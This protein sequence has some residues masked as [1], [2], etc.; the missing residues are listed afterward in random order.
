M[1]V[2]APDLLALGVEV[3]RQR[4]AHGYSIDALA[5]AAGVHRK[6]IIQ[7]EAGRVA[8]R[9]STLHGIAHALDAPLAELLDPLCRQHGAPQR[10]AAR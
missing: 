8:A 5:E 6:T 7:I 4:R 1:L 2:P 3:A 9:V 10:P